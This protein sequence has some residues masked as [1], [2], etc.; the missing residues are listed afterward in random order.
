MSK[1]RDWQSEL[2][3]VGYVADLLAKPEVQRLAE[4]PQH[5]YLNRLEHL[6]SVLYVS[7]LIGK[8]RYLNVWLIARAGLCYDLFY[9]DWRKTKFDLGTQLFIHPRMLLR[10]LEKLTELC[11]MEKDIML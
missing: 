9:Y 6:I 3:Y 1:K 5:H 7:Y 4:H 11:P 10:K 2:E 8:R